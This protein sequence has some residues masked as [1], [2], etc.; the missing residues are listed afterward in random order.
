MRYV[1]LGRL[2]IRLIVVTFAS[3]GHRAVKSGQLSKAA[4]ATAEHDSDKFTGVRLKP[5]SELMKLAED[6]PRATERLPS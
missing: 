1:T 4:T 6:I 2:L 5:A 3:R